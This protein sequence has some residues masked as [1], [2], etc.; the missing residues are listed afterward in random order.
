MKQRLAEVR[1]RLERLHREPRR[2]PAGFEHI[3]VPV[4]K[5]LGW[6][7]E[8]ETEAAR[9]LLDEARE[10]L[11]APLASEPAALDA[12][13]VRAALE[14]LEAN[15]AS[16]RGQRSCIGFRPATTSAG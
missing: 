6:R 4:L 9:A 16:S 1:Q 15:A 13:L 12:R 10:R 8:L 5:V 14:E 7:P 3:L 2:D 11:S